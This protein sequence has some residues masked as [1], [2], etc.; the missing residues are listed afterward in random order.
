MSIAAAVAADVTVSTTSTTGSTNARH[1]SYRCNNCDRDFRFSVTA[2]ATFRCPGCHRRY[3]Q[4]HFYLSLTSAPSN[5]NTSYPSISIFGPFAPS[6]SQSPL[7]TS[8]FVDSDDEDLFNSILDRTSIQHQTNRSSPTS[9][10][11]VNTLP[12]VKITR[13]LSRSCSIC[14]DDFECNEKVN[15]LPCKH[16]FHHECIVP[17]LNRRNSC[18][19]CRYKLPAERSPRPL[20]L[21]VARLGNL[22]VEGWGEDH[23]SGF[24]DAV[25]RNGLLAT[26][27][28]QSSSSGL[29]WSSTPLTRA[30]TDDRVSNPVFETERD[31]DVGVGGLANGN[32]NATVDED[33][34]TLMLDAS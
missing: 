9:K 5:P 1:R 14:K 26:L 29:S 28:R 4:R 3:V 7:H 19:L 15:R 18:P 17:W 21:Y 2:T 8:D 34:D 31:V 27:S 33:G 30:Q 12:F 11:F 13:S 10:S 22:Y 6:S 16:V 32:A 24:R 25:L 23:E 20:M